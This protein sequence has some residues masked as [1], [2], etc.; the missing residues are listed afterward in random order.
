MK[1]ALSIGV[2]FFVIGGLIGLG[3]GKMWWRNAPTSETAEISD[4]AQLNTASALFPQEVGDQPLDQMA[5]K[6]KSEE[7]MKADEAM[8]AGTDTSKQ[9]ETAAM[10]AQEQGGQKMTADDSS[11]ISGGDQAPGVQVALNAVAVKHAGWA[12]IHEDRNGKPGNILG[13]RRLDGGSYSNV[14][15]DLLRATTAGGTYYAMLHSDNGDRIFDY[16]IDV[17]LIDGGGNPIMVRFTA[18]AQ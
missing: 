11:A 12:V 1:K 7:A 13:A 3:I 18:V 6:E 9:V 10:P 14:V 4:A 17:P 8:K 5:P 16:K 2:L 15:V